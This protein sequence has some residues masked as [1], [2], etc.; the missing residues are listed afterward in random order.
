MWLT[1]RI[2]GLKTISEILRDNLKTFREKR[3]WSQEKLADEVGISRSVIALAETLETFPKQESITAIARALKIEESELF[4]DPD[5]KH[6]ITK[7]D[8]INYIQNNCEQQ[9]IKP[10]Q[11]EIPEFIIDALKGCDKVPTDKKTIDG[12]ET[13]IA[14][15]IQWALNQDRYRK[16]SQELKPDQSRL[17]KQSSG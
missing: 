15:A 8:V 14:G 9:K 6:K 17:K 1:N 7:E 5:Y 13:A 4:I 12:L 3:E 10:K 16:K 11:A 2:Y